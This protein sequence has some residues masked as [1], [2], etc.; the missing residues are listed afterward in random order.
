[1]QVGDRVGGGVVDQLRDLT[2]PE[3]QP[4]VGE[5][6]P[7]PL[8]VTRR[9]GPVPGRGPRG[10]LYEADPVVVMQGADGHPGEPGHTSHTQMLFHTPDPHP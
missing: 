7:K 8:H 5:H 4:P 6:L 10:R 3:A 9:V 1:M 2:Q